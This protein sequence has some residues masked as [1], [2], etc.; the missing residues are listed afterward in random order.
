MTHSNDHMALREELSLGRRE[1]SARFRKLPPR[2]LERGELLVTTTRSADVIYHLIA[3]WACQFHEFPASDQAIVDVYLPGDVVGLDAVLRCRPSEKIMS[4]TS[5]VIEVVIGAQHALLDLMT[6]RS[7]A[8][9]VAWLL[10][11][12]QRRSDRHVAAISSLHASGRVASMMLDF[13]ERLY[14]RNLITSPMYNFPLTQIQIA[15]YLGLTPGHVNRVL[16]S[17]RDERIACLENHCLTIL[18]LER[19]MMLAK[20][21]S[22]ESLGEGLLDEPT[23]PNSGSFEF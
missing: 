16:R 5:L 23:P 11:Q 2:T 3:G 15:A 6:C 20:D 13:Y 8:L 12:R 18:D 7:A 19:L 1:L 14:Q 22:M 4:L 21:G 10:G 9:Y 17:L